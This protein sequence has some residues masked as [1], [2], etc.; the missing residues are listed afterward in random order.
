MLP[1]VTKAPCHHIKCIKYLKYKK[2][3]RRELEE[4]GYMEECKYRKTGRL[5]NQQG[6]AKP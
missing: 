4:L 3:R 1:K 5:F 2:Q 6:L